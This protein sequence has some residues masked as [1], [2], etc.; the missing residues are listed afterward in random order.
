MSVL[1][2]RPKKPYSG[3]DSDS[4]SRIIRRQLETAAWSVRWNY[5]G[6]TEQM[7]DMS[8]MHGIDPS[9]T[10][11]DWNQTLLTKISQ[12]A[13]QIHK[14]T[15]TI[16][17]TLVISTEIESIFKTFPN[18]KADRK[19]LAHPS[20]FGHGYEVIVNDRMVSYGI[21]VTRIVSDPEV[22]FK[23]N[24]LSGIIRVDGITSWESKEVVRKLEIE[25]EGKV[26]THLDKK[27]RLL[28]KR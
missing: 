3:N 23:N 22:W 28:I 11:K 12:I 5:N 17:D 16:A 18:Y 26:V 20:G 13:D 27:Y 1:S 10:Q 15:N 9:C 14:S 4:V 7:R 2:R 8:M 6:A 24:R 19:Y 25:K 21:I